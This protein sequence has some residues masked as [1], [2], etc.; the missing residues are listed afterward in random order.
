MGNF[1]HFILSQKGSNGDGKLQFSGRDYNLILNHPKSEL[2]NVQISNGFWIW[3]FGIQAPTKIGFERCF[4]LNFT[5]RRRGER[6]Q[7]S[8]LGQRREEVV[9]RLLHGTL[10][11]QLCVA[12]QRK[13]FDGRRSKQLL[14]KKFKRPAKG[15]K[16]QLGKQ[17]RFKTVKELCFRVVPTF[18]KTKFLTCNQML[19]TQEMCLV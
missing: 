17:I 2:Q 9:R 11:R 3:M 12:R 13:S 7:G 19:L 4:W 15:G 10:R 5:A 16:K 8:S 18:F 6:D 14:S 1:T